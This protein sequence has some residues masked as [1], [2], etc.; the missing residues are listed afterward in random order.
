VKLPNAAHA[1]VA[2]EKIVLYLL[3]P[4]HPQNSGKA[5]FFF[6]FGFRRDAWDE[7]AAA[8]R[9]HTRHDVAA[10]INAS[11]GVVYTIEGPLNAPDGRMPIVRSVW[12]IDTG[13]TAP[14]FITAYPL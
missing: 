14:R 5:A 12:Q 7:M 13:K 8:F 6:R 10:V 3:V 4:E 11:F 1:I 2:E 9:E